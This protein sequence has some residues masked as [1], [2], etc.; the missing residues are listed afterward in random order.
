VHDPESLERPS[1]S[2]DGLGRPARD[3]TSE[4]TIP[5][6]SRRDWVYR[7]MALLGPDALAWI[8]DDR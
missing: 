8:D 3:A 1:L 2:V 5:G 7:E 4:S 6:A